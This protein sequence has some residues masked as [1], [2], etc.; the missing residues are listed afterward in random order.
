[1]GIPASTKI[2]FPA[3]VGA[4]EGEWLWLERGWIRASD[5][6]DDTEALNY[7]TKQIRLNPD[8]VSAR[9]RRAAVYLF[10]GNR[11]EFSINECNAA[12]RR[13]LERAMAHGNRILFRSKPGKDSFQDVRREACTISFAAHSIFDRSV[14]RQDG[15][16]QSS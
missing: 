11:L 16:C 1:M 7:L 8:D 2:R 15:H 14:A 12:L 5:V 10:V 3:T 6:M 4:A 9:C 13:D